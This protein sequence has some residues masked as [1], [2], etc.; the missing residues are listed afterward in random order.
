EHDA[1][2]EAWE[3]VPVILSLEDVQMADGSDAYNVV[4]NE[5]AHKIDMMSGAEDG[6][7]PRCR[8]RHAPA[9]DAQLWAAVF[10]PPSDT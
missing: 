4:I 5:F 1:S 7:Q 6:Q 3:G 2:G 8:R 10:D 9:L